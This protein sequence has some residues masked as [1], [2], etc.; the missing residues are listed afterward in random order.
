MKC[1]KQDL[2]S[3]ALSDLL[4]AVAG[5]DIPMSK[6]VHAPAGKFVFHSVKDY[7]RILSWECVQGVRY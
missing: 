6:A 3:Y 7:P 1:P 5:W 4:S 2:A